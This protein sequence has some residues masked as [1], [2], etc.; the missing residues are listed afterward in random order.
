MRYS[1]RSRQAV[2]RKVLPPQSIAVREATL[3]FGISELAIKGWL[4]LVQEG[5]LTAE[6]EDVG[7]RYKA[8][9]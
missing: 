4:K 7:P 5:K 9:S 2:L 3:E 8:A 1:S 6:E